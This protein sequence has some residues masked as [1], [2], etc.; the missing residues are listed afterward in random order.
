VGGIGSLIGTVIGGLLIG[1]AAGIVGM[2]FPSAAELVIYLMMVIVLLFR[3]RGL[4]GQKE[5]LL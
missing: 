3:P 2:F 5:I 1:V 4:F